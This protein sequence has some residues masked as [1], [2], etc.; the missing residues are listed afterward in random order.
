[1]PAPD[2]NLLKL[3]RAHR[4]EIKA[5]ADERALFA[6]AYLNHVGQM[7]RAVLQS[8]L[9]LNAGDFADV[10]STLTRAELVGERGE[11]LAVTPRGQRVLEEI[12]ITG[13]SPPP[14]RASERANGSPKRGGFRWIAGLL[15]IVGLLAAGLFILPNWV[16]SY[17]DGLVI[18]SDLFSSSASRP[19]QV[20][21]QLATD[22]PWASDTPS[23]T[24]PPTNTA[25]VTPLPSPTLV[26]TPGR[27]V[28]AATPAPSMSPT[29]NRAIIATVTKTLAPSPTRTR[30]LTPTRTLIPTPTL[31][32]TLTPTRDTL[33]PSISN[34]TATPN[35]AS[36]STAGYTVCSS[37]TTLVV[38][39]N[40][41][42]N[43]TI[44][45][46]VAYY[47]YYRLNNTPASRQLSAPMALKV[48]YILGVPYPYYEADIDLNKEANYYLNAQDGQI[49]YWVSATDGAGNRSESKQQAVA[50]KHCTANPF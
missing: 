32:P 13:G 17:A 10:L 1:M 20:V 4:D 15:V 47:S 21:A 38:K 43:V 34:V 19:T 12:G 45:S 29:A 49:M 16:S 30:A 27:V 44:A 2:L 37:A 46:V 8:D 48:V 18:I 40:V 31:I 33:P 6:L 25:V 36:Y 26:L 11:T 35:P 5:L 24:A 3:Y 23:A 7:P 22:T 28:A 42:D 41:S 9:A 50:V 14:P 39:S